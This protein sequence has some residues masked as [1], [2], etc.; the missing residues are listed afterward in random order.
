LEKDGV[1]VSYVETYWR[2]SNL[3][4][5]AKESGISPHSKPEIVT[6]DLAETSDTKTLALTI[7]AFCYGIGKKKGEATYGFMFVDVDPLCYYGHMFSHMYKR[8][9]TDV[10]ARLEIPH[11]EGNL[12]FK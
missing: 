6:R 3:N 10:M 4:E 8:K 12:G 5:F 11:N 1:P 7:N 2:S 9:I